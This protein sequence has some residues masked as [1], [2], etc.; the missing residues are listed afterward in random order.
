M[1]WN[2]LLSRYTFA[3]TVY[4]QGSLSIKLPANSGKLSATDYLFCPISNFLEIAHILPIAEG[5]NTH[6]FSLLTN[7]TAWVRR[8][9]T[10]VFLLCSIID[11]DIDLDI[12]KRGS[13]SNKIYFCKHAFLMLWNSHSFEM[14]RIAKIH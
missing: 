9:R 6:A 8:K 7:F 4:L 5:D 1:K 10:Q 2:I 3:E 11:L 12:C 13:G 14:N